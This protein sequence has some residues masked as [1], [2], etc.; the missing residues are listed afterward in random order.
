MLFSQLARLCKVLSAQCSRP[1]LVEWGSLLF[2]WLRS[3]NPSCL[4]FIF[5]TLG[6]SSPVLAQPPTLEVNTA[7]S[8]DGYYVLAWD[9][10]VDAEEPS[11]E[12]RLEESLDQTFSNP[13]L[14]YLGPDKSRVISGKPNGA[15]Y[16]RVFSETLSTEASETVA[17]Q[18]LHHSLQRA[19]FFFF[20]GFVV[21]GS[22]LVTVLRGMKSHGVDE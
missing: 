18:V 19:F 1:G 6:A 21:F 22:I 2:S 14:V 4:I 11:Q 17:V 10:S 16:Y 3:A 13:R 5:F 8:T 9:N 20:L 15:Y 12:F 7:N